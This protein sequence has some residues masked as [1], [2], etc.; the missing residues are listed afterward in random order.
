MRDAAFAALHRL[1][2]GTRRRSLVIEKIDGLAVADSLQREA[3][4]QAGFIADYRGLAS[5]VTP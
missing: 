1:P 5:E 3:L 4:L 2:R